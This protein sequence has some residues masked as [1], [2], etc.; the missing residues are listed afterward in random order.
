MTL[1]AISLVPFE[2]GGKEEDETGVG[3]AN[4]N[5]EDEYV[6]YGEIDEATTE[7]SLEDAIRVII[8]QGLV[9]KKSEMAELTPVEKFE[10]LYKELQMRDGKG[11]SGLSGTRKKMDAGN[12][13]EHLLGGEQTKDPFDER[14]VMI[15]L[16]NILDSEDFKELFLDPAVG[17]WL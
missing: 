9:N 16:R 2:E 13:L 6:E 1:F 12:M 14:K 10:Q 7:K 8:D 5:A 3:F 11:P 15:K 4:P 17:D